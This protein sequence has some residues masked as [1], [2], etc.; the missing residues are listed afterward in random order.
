MRPRGGALCALAHVLGALDAQDL[1]GLVEVTL[2][3]DQGV[4]AGLHAGAGELAE[5]LDVGGGE[6]R[7]VRRSSLVSCVRWAVGKRPGR[8]PVRTVSHIDGFPS[9]R[10]YSAA[11]VS[12]FSAGA[13]VAAACSAGASAAGASAGVSACSAA[14]PAFFRAAAVS[15][16]RGLGGPLHGGGVMRSG[17][18]GGMA[19]SLPGIGKSTSSGSQWC[20]G[21][22]RPDVE[23][24]RLGNGDVAPCWCRRSTERGGPWT[25]RGCAEGALQLV[26]S[27]V[28]MRI[29]FLVRPS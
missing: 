18:C 11:G 20:P 24:L 15:R 2:G 13:S 6:I 19:S 27:R 5:L 4:L 26:R 21:W 22:R 10:N 3:L 12:A 14:S 17:R 16:S 8:L 9:P 29:S 28:S 23:L 25:C 1:D 7:H